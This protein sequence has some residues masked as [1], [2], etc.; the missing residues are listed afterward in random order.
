[1]P[2]SDSLDVL[3]VASTDDGHADVVLQVLEQSGCKVARLSLAE[4]RE[5]E[6]YWKCETGFEVR[7]NGRT[8]RLSTATTIWWRRPGALDV[9]DLSVED[10][11]LISAEGAALFEGILL[12]SQARW[13]D[14][15]DV[16]D[17]AE[18]KLF[19]L[20]VAHRLGITVP[21]TIVTN[22]ET[23]ARRLARETIV[24]AKPVSSGPGLAPF[25]NV[26]P[27]DL[28]PLIQVAPALLQEAVSADAD[29]RIVTVG[30]SAF[31]WRRDKQPDEPIDW[32]E[33]APTGDGFKRWHGAEKTAADAV[34]VAESLGLTMS[35]QDWLDIDG[36]TT[37]LE[38]N[39]QGAWLFLSGAAEE[40]GPAIA[41]HLFQQSNDP[42]WP[43][44]WRQ[45]LWD[46]LPA[47]WAPAQS[48]LR[49]PLPDRPNWLGEDQVSRPEVLSH[50]RRAHDWEQNR[51][52][53]TEAKGNRLATIS[54]GLVALALSFVGHHLANIPSSSTFLLVLWWSVGTA[55]I[56]AILCLSISAVDAFEVD[57]VGAYH[58]VGAESLA[59]AFDPVRELVWIEEKGR[60]LAS[61]S[62]GQKLNTLL[63]ARAWFSRGIALL[64]MAAL[65]WIVG[66]IGPI[67]P[68]P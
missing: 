53:T 12:S 62:A 35:V 41:E 39:P 14:H 56:L 55:A 17:R 32:R 67:F 59:K 29:L 6:I 49:A 65:L 52:E 18:K 7:W 68:A 1:M 36:E 25:V 13:V 44:A 57:R 42:F 47:Q 66:E 24:V 51:V 22:S 10:A 21:S 37:F 61:W 48:G 54:M 64:L 63:Q 46:F 11:E 19:Q 8:L 20:V 45:F 30:A 15:P 2:T 27:D 3:I 50:A 4:F 33:S 34:R 38:C 5:S 40:V 28:L 58:Q 60:L 31:V 26:V 16:V 43:P 9:S 23:E